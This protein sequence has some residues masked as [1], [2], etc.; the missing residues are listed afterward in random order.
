MMAKPSP[1]PRR[2]R[3][4]YNS[5]ISEVPFEIF[6]SVGMLVIPEFRIL[7]SDWLWQQRDCQSIEARHAVG[8]GPQR[9]PAGF[10]KALVGNAEQSLAVVS[11]GEPVALGA[12]AERMPLLRGHFQIC[13]AELFAPAIDHP[14]EADVI[15]QRIGAGDIVIVGVPQPHHDARGLI[16]L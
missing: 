3:A 2:P 11:D 15:L 16:D 4:R 1:N 10:G 7:N 6:E 8:L 5:G 14:V 12:Q 9:D 13:A